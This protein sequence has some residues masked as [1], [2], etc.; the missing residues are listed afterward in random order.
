MTPRRVL[1]E[2]LL[3]L[4]ALHGLA[5]ENMTR[6]QAWRFVDMGLRIERAVYLCTLLHA[7]LH[8]P[9]AENPSVLEAVL[10]VA[11]SSITF[12]SRYTLLPTVPP[13]FDLVLLD[14][15]NPRSVLFQIRQLAKHFEHLPKDRE[16]S[17]GSGK[18]IIAKCLARLN[19]TDARELAARRP[20]L[21][22]ERG[23][24]GHPT[25][26]CKPC[27]NCPT[28]SPPAISPTRRFRA[29]AAAANNEVPHHPSHAVR[30]LRAGDGLAACHPAGAAHFGT[31]DCEQFSLKIFPEPALRKTAAGL[32]RQP[33][34]LFHH[35]GDPRRL[36]IIT[37][38]RVTV[39]A[40]KLPAA[41]NHARLGARSADLFR[42]P[43][44]PEVV[45]P[46]QFVFDSPQVRA[47]LALADYA[48]AS[49][50]GDTPLLAGVADLTRRIFT[51]FK[52]D[53]KAT[54]V[55]TPLEEVWK[56]RRGVC[57]DFAHL[58]IA[59]LRSL[60]LPARY[61]SGYLRTR[62][63]AGQP[64]LVGADASHA[65]FRVFCPGVGLGGFRPHQQRAARRGTH[66]RGLRP[67]FRRRQPRGRH[68][69]RRRQAR[70][71]SLR[72]RGGRLPE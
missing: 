34:L 35:P 65:W 45:E 37:H 23:A 60:G 14:D 67:R 25:K 7:T 13:V 66:R 4:A 3:G 48:L 64:R 1:N 53:P 38:S 16:S 29:P 15:K 27:R 47:S 63:P 26:F 50:T 22:A 71:E 19:Q 54:T 39:T 17:P 31:Q 42:D 46:Y 72:G 59:C 6:A 18:S 5:R 70:R 12:R 57:Q 20:G 49:F 55:A 62:P 30:I 58:G 8:S 44:S 9:D 24:G 61:V 68:P 28:P 52:F 40:R 10:E 56:N 2:T 36:E 69:D 43:V 32:F 41:R 21:A 11:D 33:A 51:D